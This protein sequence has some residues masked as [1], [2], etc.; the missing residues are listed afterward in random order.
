MS[1]TS[2]LK[3]CAKRGDMTISDL[4]LWFARPRSTVLTWVEHGRTPSGP[5]AR[6]AY[7][8][9]ELLKTAV[10]NSPG[11][12]IPESLA[13]KYRTEHVRGLRDAARRNARI[14]AMRAAG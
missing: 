7:R 1:F 5:S 14:P 10:R 6:D 12:P 4:A 3:A 11:F 13:W 2:E 8:M 9:L